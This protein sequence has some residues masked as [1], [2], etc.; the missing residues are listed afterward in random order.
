MTK[1]AAQNEILGVCK[2]CEKYMHTRKKPNPHQCFSKKCS[3]YEVRY[4]RKTYHIR[5]KTSKG[6]TGKTGEK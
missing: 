4:C 1:N 2:Y 5:K 6:I 3:I